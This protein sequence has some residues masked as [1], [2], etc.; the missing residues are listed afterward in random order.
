MARLIVSRIR[1][2]L[3][4]STSAE[5]VETRLLDEITDVLV[6]YDE[7]RC[8]PSTTMKQLI[9]LIAPHFPSLVLDV[10]AAV[11][12]DSLVREDH[13]T[14]SQSSVESTADS[15]PCLEVPMCPGM[16]VADYHMS[17][18][19]S[20]ELALS[21][22]MEGLLKFEK[23][24][25]RSMATGADLSLEMSEI[26]S[27]LPETLPK[28]ELKESLPY[29]QNRYIPTHPGNFPPREAMDELHRADAQIANLKFLRAVAP[30]DLIMFAD[31]LTLVKSGALHP[32]DLWDAARHVARQLESED[33]KIFK[34]SVACVVATQLPALEESMSL[35]GELVQS[36]S[37][38]GSLRHEDVMAIKANFGDHTSIIL[39]AIRCSQAFRDT[40]IACLQ[41]RVQ[42]LEARE[43][44]KAG[45]PS[46]LTT[47]QSTLRCD[48]QKSS[49][50]DRAFFSLKAIKEASL[51]PMGF[52]RTFPLEV[53]NMFRSPMEGLYS[54][55]HRVRSTF[56]PTLSAGINPNLQVV[57]MPERRRKLQAIALICL[58]VQKEFAGDLRLPSIRSFLLYFFLPL[59]DEEGRQTLLRLLVQD[60]AE[61]IPT[62]GLKRKRGRPRKRQMLSDR[63]DMPTSL[64]VLQTL[65]NGL[66][67]GDYWGT[68]VSLDDALG[69]MLALAFPFFPDGFIMT[70]KVHAFYVMVYTIYA[71][72]MLAWSVIEPVRHS[73]DQLLTRVVGESLLGAPNK[74]ARALDEGA[75]TLMHHITMILQEEGMEFQSPDT[76]RAADIMEREAP[77]QAS[78]IVGLG[79]MAITASRL[80]ASIVDDSTTHQTHFAYLSFAADFHNKVAIQTYWA[81]C[82]RLVADQEMLTLYE[83]VNDLVELTPVL[84]EHINETL[85]VEESRS[86]SVILHS[87]FPAEYPGP[88]NESLDC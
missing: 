51:D 16:P 5:S 88:E 25:D 49:H 4:L 1:E 38:G 84:A 23:L 3:G 58:A 19:F 82:K 78:F 60:S 61:T 81:V 59:I 18:T 55:S 52:K 10:L 65:G 6:A 72:L 43:H 87:L 73:Y 57:M 13:G 30:E 44:L 31:S 29:F 14:V 63:F 54:F 76:A 34:N 26:L 17:L 79:P 50:I 11:P 67:R 74:H 83:N 64:V 2:T 56:F 45:S 40:L 42:D 71:R 22:D 36:L 32:S 41:L 77:L 80:L 53:E 48:S 69:H 27:S 62:G 15:L 70:Q 66:L 86:S 7:L 21:L 33:S 28:H 46:R 12:L 24:L 20:R 37:K 47:A 39:E 85:H 75:C 35:T 68:I 9:G 8:D